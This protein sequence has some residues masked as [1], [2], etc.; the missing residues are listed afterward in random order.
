MPN[1]VAHRGYVGLR[2][3]IS[4]TT[5]KP[6]IEVQPS[7]TASTGFHSGRRR[8][9][10]GITRY[11]LSAIEKSSYEERLAALEATVAKPPHSTMLP[12]EDDPNFDFVQKDR[13]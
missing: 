12:F 4:W 7:L 13:P 10:S 5:G 1:R 3:S 2:E 8:P 6:E 11:V 9:S